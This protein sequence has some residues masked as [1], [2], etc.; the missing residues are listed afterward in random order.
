MNGKA[1]TDSI[2][3]FEVLANELKCFHSVLLHYSVNLEYFSGKVVWD[4]IARRLF[5]KMCTKFTNY[6]C[7]K[8]PMGNTSEYLSWLLEWVSHKIVFR[9]LELGINLVQGGS[10]N[11]GVKHSLTVTSNPEK[12]LYGNQ[13]YNNFQSYSKNNN[14]QLNHP[15]TEKLGCL[16]CTERWHDSFFDCE[17]FKKC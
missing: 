4:V 8:G 11:I 2:A 3:D 17:K 5:K 16:F 7:N 14:N 10:K 1:I 6:I 13:C 15:Y 9:Q 12:K